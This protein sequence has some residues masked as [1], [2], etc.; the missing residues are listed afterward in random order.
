MKS[1]SLVVL[2]LVVVL[3]WLTVVV[4]GQV[5]S[6][7]VVVG[8]DDDIEVEHYQHHLYRNEFLFEEH[9][10]LL[11][12]ALEL[13][14]TT[15][16]SGSGNI[17]SSGDGTTSGSGSYYNWESIVF[18]ILLIIFGAAYC[19][20]GYRLFHIL[21]FIL[22]WII[23]AVIFW[24]V[25]EEHTTLAPWAVLV[26]AVTI[27]ILFG[28]LAIVFYFIGIFV[29]G[30]LLG[31]III[32]SI[33]SVKEGTLIPNETV[34][35]VVVV[36]FSLFCGVL[37]IFLQKIMIIVSTA[38]TGAYWIV[39]GIDYLIK[40]NI[41]QFIP[42]MFRG[43]L[44]DLQTN[45]KTWLM[46]SFLIVLSIAGIVVQLM[47]TSKGHEFT[48]LIRSERWFCKKKEPE[49]HHHDDDVEVHYHTLPQ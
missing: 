23:G 24:N 3:A 43:N 47:K 32:S 1:G 9:F 15:S 27:G 22:G 13:S 29:V 18:S 14:E 34:R 26:I 28:I 39:S 2:A 8:V 40:G 31:L 30:A 16:G 38:I 48:P 44:E 20:F 17:S 35:I 11:R 46:L 19:F 33:L 37:A 42:E 49:H 12:D 45:W 4:V 7:E 6:K 41:S 10:R 25:L 21:L 5:S 36:I